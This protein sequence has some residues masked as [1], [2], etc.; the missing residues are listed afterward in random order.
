LHQVGSQSSR[1]NGM[2]KSKLVSLQE[3]YF[4]KYFYEVESPIQEGCIGLQELKK[5]MQRLNYKVKINSITPQYE[6]LSLYVCP[7]PGDDK[8][9][10]GEVQP[11]RQEQH[12]SHRL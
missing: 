9:S 11:L 4:R 6:T 8:H 1:L 7:T 5:L 10:E 2:S 12:W 3:R